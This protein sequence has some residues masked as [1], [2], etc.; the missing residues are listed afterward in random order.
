R[1]ARLAEIWMRYAWGSYGVRIGVRGIGGAGL[2]QSIERAVQALGPGRPV[3]DVRFLSDAVADASSDTRFALFVL[4]TFAVLALVLTAVGVYAS[5]AY[6]TSTRT[7]E[8][9]V[10]RA[11]GAEAA[12]ILT[13]VLRLAAGWT[14][15]GLVS[16]VP[17]ALA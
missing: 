3:H 16:L 9:A 8:I 13:P 17:G 15:A 4:G 12:G 1:A 7:R 11:P 10:R 5:V 14:A 6:A 2:A